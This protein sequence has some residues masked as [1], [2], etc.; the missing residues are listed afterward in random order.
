MNSN[1]RAVVTLPSENEILITRVFAAP[2]ELVFRAHTDPLLIPRWWGPRNTTTIVDHM[3]VRPGGTYR[4]VHRTPDGFEVVFRGE[5]REIVPHERLVQTSEMEGNPGALLEIMTFT[6]RDGLTTLAARE[7]CPSREVRDAVL[8]SGMEEG[9]QES[10]VRLDEL[11][12]SE[13]AAAS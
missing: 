3:D 11:F 4:F 7:V 10:Y 1:N 12:A 9:L 8:A 6:E 5:F 2:R 13:Q